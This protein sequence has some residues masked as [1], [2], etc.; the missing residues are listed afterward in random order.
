MTTLEKQVAALNAKV[1]SLIALL[2]KPKRKVAQEAPL[3]LTTDA[4]I[5]KVINDTRQDLPFPTW[6][7]MGQPT[8]C[9]TTFMDAIGMGD[10]WTIVH[11]ILKTCGRAPRT[12]ANMAPSDGGLIHIV[13]KEVGE[14]CYAHVEHIRKAV[15]TVR[16]RKG[17]QRLR[18]LG[19]M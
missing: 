9:L 7:L 10:D 4:R 16:P 1:D 11:Q 13:R 18:A 19:L 6:D 15:C 17:P 3:L 12:I 2:P 5:A 14:S 8:T